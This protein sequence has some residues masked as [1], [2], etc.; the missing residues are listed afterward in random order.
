M[1]L[2]KLDRVIFSL[3]PVVQ[4]KIGQ[5]TTFSWCKREHAAK[6]HRISKENRDKIYK[7]GGIEKHNGFEGVY[8]KL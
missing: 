7:S 8:D 2:E 4:M 1:C 3:I 5:T 6:N